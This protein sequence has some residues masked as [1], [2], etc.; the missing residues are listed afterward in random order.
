[1]IF[2]IKEVLRKDKSILI[3]LLIVPLIVP[4]F[5]HFVYGNIYVED[6]PFGIVDLDN[7]SLSRTIVQGLDNHPGLDTD[8]VYYSEKELEEAILHKKVCGGIIIPRGLSKDMN[9]N[10]KSPKVLLI[11]DG[12]NIMVGNN[13]AG[14]VSAVLGTFNAGIQM[15]F[16]EGNGMPADSAQ[17]TI[18]TFSYGER[19]LYEPFLSYIANIVYILIPFLIQTYFL[20]CFLLPAFVEEKHYWIRYDLT[21]TE[22]RQRIQFLL[23]R[24]LVVSVFVCFASYAAF[25]AY[26]HVR[27]M[28][29][30]GS[31]A[32][33]FIVLF[34]FLLALSAISVVLTAFFNEKNMIY[35]IEFYY[36]ISSVIM[37]TSGA[38]WPE[39]MMPGFVVSLIKTIWPFFHV[40][41]PIK[42]INLK[43]VGWDQIFGYAGN[44]LI[45]FIVWLPI[46][47]ILLK[48]KIRILKE[49]NRTSTCEE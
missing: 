39:Y 15:S 44:S 9:S 26:A 37:V 20:T 40:A 25:L 45:Y 47:L 41:L 7:S 17:K 22:K 36:I 6:I 34:C 19:V 3:M 12:T 21:K 38:V 23:T 18:G 32:K 48:R 35:F 49:K 43:G 33:Y 13:A 2:N 8:Y 28:P 5:M 1:M 14:Y 27:N 31:L 30:R 16:L 4:F 29:L 46:G 10:S 42:F 11:V 24:V